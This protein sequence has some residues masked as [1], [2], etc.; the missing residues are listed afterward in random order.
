M[1]SFL[2]VLWGSIGPGASLLCAHRDYRNSKKPSTVFLYT[3]R[4]SSIREILRTRA[5]S[6]TSTNSL[7]RPIKEK[8]RD[9]AILVF[10]VQ[11]KSWS[12]QS[13]KNT[14]YSR[15]H[16]ANALVST[17]S[18]VAV[19]GCDCTLFKPRRVINK[20]KRPFC[21]MP[22]EVACIAFASPIRGRSDLGN[23]GITWWNKGKFHGSASH[24]WTDEAAVLI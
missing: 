3:V 8:R 12:N 11:K 4:Y 16:A 18:C 9:I 6:W 2:V 10:I 22:C 23:A 21:S 14:C 19:L 17:V 7:K 13:I 15:E 5:W 1:C 20:R 24:P